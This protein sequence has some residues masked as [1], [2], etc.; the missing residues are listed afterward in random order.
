MNKK[1]VLAAL[2]K[3]QKNDDWYKDHKI[4]GQFS[5]L[6]EANRKLLDESI[7]LL[8]QH[9]NE[10]VWSN[11][12]L[13]AV[14]KF[15]LMN[16]LSAPPSNRPDDLQKF[17]E[18]N[19]ITIDD[20]YT[21]RIQQW[22]NSL[23]TDNVWSL[24]TELQVY[25]IKK[26]KDKGHVITKDAR[27][28]LSA[29]VV[30]KL[31]TEDYFQI[32]RSSSDFK[33][34]FAIPFI[35]E[36]LDEN[37]DN[38]LRQVMEYVLEKD[39]W[40]AK[41]YSRNNV[42]VLENL[43]PVIELFITCG[44]DKERKRKLNQY[45]AKKLTQYFIERFSSLGAIEE[46]LLNFF[47]EH[48]DFLRGAFSANK[49]ATLHSLVDEILVDIQEQTT[50]LGPEKTA[51]IYQIIQNIP[52]ISQ[53]RKEQ[54]H[55]YY[56]GWLLYEMLQDKKVTKD[57]WRNSEWVKTLANMQDKEKIIADVELILDRWFSNA[58]T[59]EQRKTLLESAEKGPVAIAGFIIAE[60]DKQIKTLKQETEELKQQNEE[61]KREN[62]WL[63]SS[64]QDHILVKMGGIFDQSANK[65]GKVV[66]VELKTKKDQLPKN[67]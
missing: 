52:S 4:L 54:S 42:I 53:N 39:F 11:K 2:Q 62:K 7:T 58:L 19:C 61:L 36:F 67:K 20:T 21:D 25:T 63:E 64:D 43:T 28:K 41:E 8:V 49:K 3:Y 35:N 32:R 10:T 33:S 13:C 51:E 45:L 34:P 27:K 66:S 29:D 18:D 15:L 50:K 38:A 23:T 60:K 6:S 48:P 30:A 59:K 37:E 9:Q 14:L 56:T 31:F 26:R 22:A 1:E 40:C 44:T 55:Q 5:K 24:F 16:I 17:C 12:E 57:S 65:E 46:Q 47:I